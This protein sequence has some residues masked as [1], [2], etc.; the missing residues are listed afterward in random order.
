[1]RVNMSN[2]V[3]FAGAVLVLILSFVSIYTYID[4][5]MPVSRHTAT[6]PHFQENSYSEND[7]E[8]GTYDFPDIGVKLQ[9]ETDTFFAKKNNYLILFLALYSVALSVLFTYRERNRALNERLNEQIEIEK[10]HKQQ[11]KINIYENIENE[12]MRYKEILSP[13]LTLEHLDEKINKE[14][15]YILFASRTVLE[16]VIRSICLKYDMETDKLV[17]MIR[18]LYRKRILDPQTNGYAHTIRAFGNR[19]AHP[20]MD[21]PMHFTSKDALLVLSILV[22]LL[23]ELHARRLLQELE[24]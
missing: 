23:N 15:N 11:S 1:M 3:V 12:L 20:S 8:L 16:K 6:K 2:P 18:R 10:A 24:S 14:V 5:G 19:A 4:R 13:E 17:T 7:H 21:N 22:T 9:P